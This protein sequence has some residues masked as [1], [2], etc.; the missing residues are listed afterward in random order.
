[1]TLLSRFRSWLRAI[2]RRS[3]M[4]SEMDTELR[5]HLEAFAED[6]VRSGVPRQEAQRR[7][8]MEFGGIER[9]KEECL[10]ATGANFFDSLVQDIR[11]GFRQ[12]RKSPGF[13]AVAVLTLA[14]GI[15]ANTA[16]FGVLNA[17]LLK[18][19]PVKNPSQLVLL[20][21]FDRGVQ[22]DFSYEEFEQVRDHSRSL[23]GVFAFDTDRLVVNAREQSYFVWGQCVS[24]NFFAVLG[25]NPFLGR[26]L[27]PQDDQPEAIPVAVVSYEFWRQKLG[28]DPYISGKTVTLKNIPFKIAGVAPREFLGIERGGA[29]DIWF[30]MTYWKQL[31]LNDHTEVGMMARLVSGVTQT[32]ASAE[33]STI[34]RAAI[35]EIAGGSPDK[36]ELQGRRVEA[37]P[38]SVGEFDLSERL[39]SELSILMVVVGVVLLIACANIAN[40]QLARAANRGREIAVRLALGAGRCRLI[41]QLLTE[42]IFLAI[43]GGGL[44]LLLANWIDRLLLK[45]ALGGIDPNSLDLRT[46][47]RVLWFTAGA[48]VLT[49]ILFGLAPALWA[50]HIDPGPALKIGRGDGGNIGRRRPLRQFLV[51]A[52]VALCAVLLVGAGLLVRSLRE[53]SRVNP[54]FRQENVL[55]VSF[56]PTLSGYQGEAELR[57]YDALQQHIAAIPGV[58][59]VSF[60][61]FNLLSGASATRTVGVHRSARQEQIEVNCYPVS[62]Q[63][64][65]TVQIPILM[66]RGFAPSDGA[67]TPAVVVV[68]EAFVQKYF[69]NDNPVGHQ[70]EFTE[71]QQPVQVEIVGVAKSVRSTT[72]RRED[73]TPAVYVPLAQTPGEL[74]GQIIMHVRSASQVASIVPA[75]RQTAQAIDRN[76]PL[77]N[78][79]T[80][81]LYVEDSLSDERSLATLSSS[82]GFLAAL[83]ATL[84]LYGVLAYLVALRT[85]EIGI[86]LALGAPRSGLLWLVL[87]EGLKLASCGIAV[88]ILISFLFTRLLASLL[89]GIGAGD[90]FTLAAVAMFLLAVAL[91]ACY[92]PA[93]RA[94][95]VDPMVALRYE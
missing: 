2:V 63:F 91:A 65:E 49:G 39:P 52:Q 48:S 7:A 82:F 45:F 26:T 17:V 37:A 23:D 47:A 16:I 68:S 40:L 33:L 77:I 15:G 46:D 74:L 34:D 58:E 14:L 81:K 13:F 92:I 1:M 3:R 54:G 21:V 51:I 87:K 79:T 5:F 10:D 19:L 76:L 78:I 28:S 38:G 50:S 8:R 67:N 36:S 90:P 86:R 72:L 55:L 62:P 42:S 29:I 30:P 11:F 66:G 75:I 84:G 43:C 6:L 60:S 24:G 53:L 95:R 27:L 64:F 22:T 57:L 20:R 93:R 59:A 85:P 32:Q 41:R 70:I 4:E 94:M 61:R 83:L 25:V 35:V 69:Q 44:G 31:R 71:E 56:Y 73:S 88:G 89:F 18:E 9:A 12:L 80:Q